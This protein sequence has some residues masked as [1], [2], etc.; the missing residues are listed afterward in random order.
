MPNI[1]ACAINFFA[2]LVFLME[3]SVVL[4]D[5]SADGSFAF[6]LL[7]GL[8]QIFGQLTMSDG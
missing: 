3:C 8:P 2:E 5:W 4:E 6:L 7:K 1:R